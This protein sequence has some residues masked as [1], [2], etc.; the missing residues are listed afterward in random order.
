MEGAAATQGLRSLCFSARSGSGRASSG[1]ARPRGTPQ[2]RRTRRARRPPPGQG[3]A[4][5]MQ[6]PTLS[7]A[8]PR[9]RPSLLGLRLWR[10][11]CLSSGK[12]AENQTII[13]TIPG[14]GLRIYPGA[15]I[16]PPRPVPGCPQAPKL[17]GIREKTTKTSFLFSLPAAFRCLEKKKKKKLLPP[18]FF[19]PPQMKDLGKPEDVGG[20][21]LP[22]SRPISLRGAN[23]PN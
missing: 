11:S 15:A 4:R 16:K 6:W 7:P 2:P 17:D 3:E 21:G 10:S 5:N 19:A 23:Y 8:P 12:E 1:P 18:Y 22:Q 13:P 14:V 20:R 9:L